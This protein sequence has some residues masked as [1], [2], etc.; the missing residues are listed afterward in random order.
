MDLFY[1]G[2]AIAFW[3]LVTGYA[4]GCARAQSAGERR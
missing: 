2:L 1:I 3:L 4:R